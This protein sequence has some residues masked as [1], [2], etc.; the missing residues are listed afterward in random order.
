MELSDYE[1]HNAGLPPLFLSPGNTVLQ[2]RGTSDDGQSV[3]NV[4]RNP[5][6]H[7]TQ[8][9]IQWLQDVKRV[10]GSDTSSRVFVGQQSH[11]DDIAVKNRHLK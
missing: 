6:Y 8:I 3:F 9:I 1:C 10:G 11:K 2:A 7:A 4:G 5:V